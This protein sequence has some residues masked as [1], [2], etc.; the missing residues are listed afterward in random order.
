MNSILTIFVFF[1]NRVLTTH[2]LALRIKVRAKKGVS[3][4]I[5]IWGWNSKGFPTPMPT[6][7]ARN[8]ALFK[9]ALS[10]ET[11]GQE[12]LI[13][14]LNLLSSWASLSQSDGE[15]VIYVARDEFMAKRPGATRWTSACPLPRVGALRKM[16]RCLKTSL[17]WEKLD[18]LST[19]QG[20]YQ[21]NKVS[22]NPTRWLS[23]QQGDYQ[24]N[25]AI[26]NPTRWLSTQQGDYQPNKVIIN[27]TRWV[28]TQQGDYQP[29][30]VIINPT[31][32]LSTQQGDYQPNEVII[33][34]TRWLSTQQGDYQPNKVIVSPTRWLSTQQGDYQ[35]NK[36]IINPARWL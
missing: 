5:L 4:T 19:Q 21:P 26:I 29:N 7:T 9:K 18:G 30:K 24:P 22:I 35:P 3:H 11:N 8:K 36:V 13:W 23:T 10:R 2:Q 17:W 33:N 1:S 6:P 27:P 12:S 32:R 16:E 25:E 15:L 34:P 20:D 31:R 28:S 14:L